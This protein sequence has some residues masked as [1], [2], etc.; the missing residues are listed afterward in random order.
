MS[1]EETNQDNLL[2]ELKEQALDLGIKFNANIGAEKLQ[3]KIDEKEAEIAAKQ[4]AKK[5]AKASVSNKKVRIVVESREGDDAPSDQFFGCGSMAT[6]QRESI[7]IQ[8]GEEIEVSESMYNHIKS[9]KYG[10]KKFK[11]VPDEEGIPQ[12]EWYTKY[13]TRFIV[14]KV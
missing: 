10:E 7:L 12:K 1:V 4:K 6:G 3:E 9:I 11:L 13:K 5:E 2:E 8:F 14:S